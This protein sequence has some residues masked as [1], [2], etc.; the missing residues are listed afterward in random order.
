MQMIYPLEQDVCKQHIGKNVCVV[1]HDGSY[2]TGTLSE[3][4]DQGLV[5]G[6]APVASVRSSSISKAKQRRKK[7]GAVK[8]QAFGGYPYGGFR[9]FRNFAPFAA[10]SLLFLLPFLFI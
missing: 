1:F 3:V 9:P 2:M 6:E 8:T 10:I 7:A 4:T 5:F